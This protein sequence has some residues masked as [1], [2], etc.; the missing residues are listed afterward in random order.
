MPPSAQ[1]K[2][3]DDYVKDTDD[4]YDADN[5]ANHAD[6]DQE[7][8][9]LLGTSSSCEPQ[10]ASEQQTAAVCQVF[11]SS[12]LSKIN[13]NINIVK[14]NIIF[15]VILLIAKLKVKHHH[16]A[17]L[18]HL[19]LQCQIWLRRRRRKKINLGEEKAL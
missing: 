4:D 12:S 7:S 11:T 18:H 1:V 9:R 14:I 13:I 8:R 19:N 3:Y 16:F 15:I 2:H 10:T 17:K 5:Y 6:N